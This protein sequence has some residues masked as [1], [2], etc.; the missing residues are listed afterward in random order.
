MGIGWR[1]WT[2]AAVPRTGRLVPDSAAVCLPVPDSAV[3]CTSAKL[4]WHL[5]LECQV[6]PWHLALEC[7]GTTW[8]L[9]LGTRATNGTVLRDRAP[10]PSEKGGWRPQEAN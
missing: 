9:A 6:G 5:A 7:H 3:R 8:H 10:S 4:T 1:P 2:T